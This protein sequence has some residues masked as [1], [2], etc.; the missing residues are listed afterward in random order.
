MAPGDPG[1]ASL[2]SNA[3]APT[4]SQP[5]GRLGA[6]R[7]QPSQAWVPNPQRRPKE[8][9]PFE[10]RAQLE[11]IA[12]Q[13]G[14]VYGPMVIFGAATGLRPSE[15]FGLER[16][17]VDLEAGVVYVRRA[18][19]NGRIKNT[20]TRLST[21]VVPAASEGGRGARPAAG[22]PST[23]SCSECTRRQDRLPRLRPP[24]LPGGRQHRRRASNRSGA[25]TTCATPTRPSP[26]A[27]AFRCSRPSRFIG[28]SIAMIDR[29]YGHLAA[30]ATRMRSR[31]SMLSRS[32]R[33][34]TL[35]DVEPNPRKRPQQRQYRA[36]SRN[37]TGAWTLGGRQSSFSSPLPTTK[38]LNIQRLCRKPSTDS[39]RRPLLTII[40]EGSGGTGG[41]PRPRKPRKL[42][43]SDGED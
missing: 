24:P 25:S 5:C 18:F 3:G 30:T 1:R 20:K 35:V 41:S 39:N 14:P 23:R 32:S 19:A 34:W 43:G 21:R 22:P 26:S 16:H 33:P 10:S 6:N 7:L 13:L 2:R 8:K 17:D 15:L 31:C 36:S 12:A 28:S 11:A 27:P 29:H 37:I 42:T 4:G 38:E 9:R 40:G